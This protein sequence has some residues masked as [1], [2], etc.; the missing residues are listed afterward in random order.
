M[1]S[2]G[3]AYSKKLLEVKLP[4]VSN[5][6]CAEAMSGVINVGDLLYLYQYL[7]LSL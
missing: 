7:L 1:T 3:G 4:I 5:E 6:V 2:F